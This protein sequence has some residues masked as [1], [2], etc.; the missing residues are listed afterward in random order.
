MIFHAAN[1]IISG[2]F[3]MEVLIEI[4]SSNH[5]LSLSKLM[6]LRIKPKNK[7]MDNII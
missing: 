4:P 3:N 1:L 7:I 6:I 2:A 5:M